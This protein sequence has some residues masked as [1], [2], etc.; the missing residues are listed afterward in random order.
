MTFI[1][2]DVMGIESSK[3]DVI[4]DGPALVDPPPPLTPT[5]CNGK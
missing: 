3:N 4:S 5:L 2:D 1:L